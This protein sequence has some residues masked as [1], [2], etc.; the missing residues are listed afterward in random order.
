MS[1]KTWKALRIVYKPE[2]TDRIEAALWDLGMLGSVTESESAEEVTVCA[3]FAPETRLLTLG[4]QLRIL[5]RAQMA[6]QAIRRIEPQKIKDEDWLKKWKESY[7]A[8]AVGERFMVTPTWEEAPAA[9]SVHVLRIDPGMAFGSGTHE[10]TKLCLLAIEKYYEPGRTFL[11]VGTGSGILALA[12]A[13][14]LAAVAPAPARSARKPITAM[15]NDKEAVKVARKNFKINRVSPY[16]K[17]VVGA[18]GKSRLKKYDFV[19]ANITA[20]DLIAHRNALVGTVRNN[21]WLVL[22]GILASQDE[23]VMT[24]FDP[25][26]RWAHVEK[27]YLGEWFGVALRRSSS[28]QRRV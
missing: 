28:D 1:K 17:A 21:G 24:T 26:A 19:V 12:A 4:R 20:P 22:S 11:D 23:E 15:D 18:L 6:E 7:T 3:Y 5:L 2:A 16:T 10:S 25:A 13:K 14:I 27:Q 9:D 8:F